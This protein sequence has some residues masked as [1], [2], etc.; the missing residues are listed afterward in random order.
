MKISCPYVRGSIFGLYYISFH[1]YHS[2]DYCSFKKVLKSVSISIL[3][4]FVFF[5]TV[6]AF[7][8]F[9]VFKGM[10]IFKKSAG[11]ITGSVLNLQVN[12][13]RTDTNTEF[14]DLCKWRS[15]SYI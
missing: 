12:L 14:S 4:L 5:K 2:L 11:I 1:Q 10:P 15:S 8:G 3:I 7:L 9:C 13:T 6:L